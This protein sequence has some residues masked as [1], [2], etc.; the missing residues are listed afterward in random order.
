MVKLIVGNK[1]T[2][3]TKTLIHLVEE[4][5]KVSKGNVV[6]VEWGDALKFDLNY[7]IRLIDIKEYDISGL[8]A[9]YG[10]IAGLMS[11]NYDITEIYG[12]ATLRILCGKENKDV[13]VLAT[14]LE[15]VN[16]LTSD[17]VAVTFTVS[18]DPAELPERVQGMIQH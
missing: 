8:D 9:Y 16:K 2:G 11:G 10:F 5:S 1:G 18:C 14:F 6:C 15:R 7:S 12:D 13:E 3:K 4:A 17:K